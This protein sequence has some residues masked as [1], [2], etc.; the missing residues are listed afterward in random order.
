M[1]RRIYQ[2]LSILWLIALSSTVSGLKQVETE[3]YVVAFNPGNELFAHQVIE[4]AEDIWDDL[5][6]AYDLFKDYQKITIYITDP[7]DYANGYA[8]AGRNTITRL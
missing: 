6:T 7:G 4:V 2:Y 5:V 1:G 3:H 8:I